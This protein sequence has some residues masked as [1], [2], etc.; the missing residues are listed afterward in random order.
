M[1]T[2]INYYYVL[3]TYSIFMVVA[4]GNNEFMIFELSEYKKLLSLGRKY[5]EWSEQGSGE[6]ILTRVKRPHYLGRKITKGNYWMYK[7][8]ANPLFTP[9][10]HLSLIT[11]SADW[12]AYI[13]SPS[14]H[15]KV[16]ESCKIT[17]TNENI[18]LPTKRPMATIA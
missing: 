10:I 4:L 9:G 13:I 16:N 17:P 14:F 15:I 8:D 18:A 6:G 1:V 3:S 2:E 12:K 5:Y 11:D 7:V